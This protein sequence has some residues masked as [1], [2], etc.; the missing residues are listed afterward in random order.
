MDLQF[1]TVPFE[2]KAADETGTFEGVASVFCNIDAMGDIMDPAAFDQDLPEF[3]SDGFVGGLNHDW[4]HPI[5]RPMMAKPTADGLSVKAQLSDTEHGR[6]CRVLMRD[7]VVKKLSIGYQALDA[8]ELTGADDCLAYWEQKGYT[9]N[10]VDL[11]RCTKPTRVLRR[12]KLFEFS[13][14]TVP[15]NQ[16]ADITRVKSEDLAAITTLADMEEFLRDA[17][18]FSRREAKALISTIKALL[19]DAESAPTVEP[20]TPTEA[21]NPEPVSEP[22]PEQKASETLAETPEPEPVTV[23]VTVTPPEPPAPD[24]ADEVPRSIKLQRER[25]AGQLWAEFC[26]IQARPFTTAGD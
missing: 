17:G 8:E 25:L 4:D 3:L 5:G 21:T 16:L 19:R 9:P 13:P 23:P 18:R 7:G 26:R 1:K 14:V 6:E 2:L 24:P 11:T 12:V 22:E 15:A 20:E 10:A